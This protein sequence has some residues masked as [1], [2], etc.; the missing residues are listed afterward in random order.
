MEPRRKTTNE[1]R[2]FVKKRDLFSPKRDYTIDTLAQAGP[3]A[4]IKKE[5]L[6]KGAGENLDQ[7]LR[8]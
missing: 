3:R 6:A 8:I 5:D 1:L 4:K 2:G 7:R